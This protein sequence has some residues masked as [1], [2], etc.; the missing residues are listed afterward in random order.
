[1]KNR[2]NDKSQLIN[3]HEKLL[4][5]IVDGKNRKKQTRINVK[6]IKEWVST[7]DTSTH[8]HT[9]RDFRHERLICSNSY[10]TQQLGYLRRLF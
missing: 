9:H 2:N 10:N 5:G 7:C 1:M 3:I 4:E 6:I 8:T